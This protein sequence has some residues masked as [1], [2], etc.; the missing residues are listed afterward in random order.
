M[1]DSNDPF[2]E[3]KKFVIDAVIW[4]T[5]SLIFN[6]FCNYEVLNYISFVTVNECN[7]WVKKGKY[8][9]FDCFVVNCDILSFRDIS[10]ITIWLGDNELTKNVMPR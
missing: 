10:S 1:R 6:I 2:Y 4:G 5:Y 7:V 9:Y 8:Y 3:I